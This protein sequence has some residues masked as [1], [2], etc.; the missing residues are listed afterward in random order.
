MI[1]RISFLS[2]YP[3]RTLPGMLFLFLVT[4]LA[5]SGCGSTLDSEFLQAEPGEEFSGGDATVFADTS[6]AFS[7]PAPNLTFEQNGEFKVGNSFFEQDWVV[8]PASTTV[9]DG[10]GPTFNGRSCAACHN[11]DGRGKPPDTPEEIPLGLL[12]QISITG[13]DAAGSP[14]VEPNYGGQIQLRSNPG[15]PAEAEASVSYVEMPGT[16]GDGTAYSLR[17]PVYDFFNLAFGDFHPDIEISPRVAPQMPGMGLLEDIPESQ[18]L[19]LADP[20][21]ADG[22]GISGRPNQVWDF[23]AVETRLGRFGWKANQP[24]VRQQ[25]AGAFHADIGITSTL[26]PEQNCPSGQSECVG[27]PHGG[28]P[29]VEDDILAFV[30]FYTQTL[31]VPARRDWEDQNVLAGKQLFNDLGCVRCHHPQFTTDAN[32]VVSQLASQ[33]IRPYTDLLL[34]DM[35]EGLADG[36]TDFEA[37]GSEWRTPP[38]WGIGL[39]ETVSGHTEFLHD[40]RARNFAEAILWHGGEAEVSKEKFRQLNAGDREDLIRFLESL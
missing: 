27:A 1:Q 40:G 38:L 6:S 15:I 17:V 3:G 7:L 37:S 30:E 12:F 21:D 5:L 25:V 39:I 29:E 14:L 2:K 16:Y 34:H 4:Q 36:R 20:D 13:K 11:K 32:Y 8:A 18:I 31:A 24:N 10:L 23:L 35:G 28:I 19:A 26:F 22:D 9:R 33:T